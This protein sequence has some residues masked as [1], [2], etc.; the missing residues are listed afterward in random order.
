MRRE[1]SENNLTSV[2][3]TGNNTNSNQS[4]PQLELRRSETLN[5]STFS[6]QSGGKRNMKQSTWH[7]RNASSISFNTLENSNTH[8]A[9]VI[10]AQSGNIPGSYRDQLG[11]AAGRAQLYS[12]HSYKKGT[13]SPKSALPPLPHRNIEKS[14]ENSSQKDT[15]PKHP[16]ASHRNEGTV[17]R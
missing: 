5:S 10:T 1:N 8:L 17:T 11:T 15:T 4:N 9:T 12:R 13:D 2:L 16:T 3:N 6:L 14:D 7:S